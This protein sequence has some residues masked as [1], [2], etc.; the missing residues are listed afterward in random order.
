[1]IDSKLVKDDYN[2]SFDSFMIYTCGVKRE[3]K[4]RMKIE[5]FIR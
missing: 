5:E 4:R 1:M 2:V 3:L